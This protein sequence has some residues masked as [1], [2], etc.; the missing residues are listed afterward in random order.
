MPKGPIP[1]SFHD[2]LASRA[3]AFVSTLGRSGEPQVTPIWFMWDGEHLQFGV[4]EGRQKYRNLIRDNRIAIAIAHPSNPYR[5]LEVRGRISGI[6]P[7]IDDALFNA[8]SLKYSGQP[9]DASRE[10]SARYVATVE[11]ERHTFQ[12]P[13]EA[14]ETTL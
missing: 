1:P 5:Y 6:T 11:V 2:L 4:L 10:S 3:F 14:P 13:S 8:V 7:D 12:E 9:F